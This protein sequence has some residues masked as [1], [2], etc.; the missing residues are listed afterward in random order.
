[1]HRNTNSKNTFIMPED[2]LIAV[3]G[4]SYHTPGIGRTGIWDY[5][6][7]P[8]RALCGSKVP[9]GKHNSLLIAETLE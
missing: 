6:S 1:M 4:L 3:I 2:T 7:L 9:R 5:L 8:T